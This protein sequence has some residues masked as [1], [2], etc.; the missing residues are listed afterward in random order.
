MHRSWG[1]GKITTVDTVFARFTID[2][3]DQGRPHDGSGLCRR[4]AQAH[5]QG[6]HSRPQSFR[7]RRPA[8]DG[9]TASSRSDQ[10]RSQSYGGKATVDQIQQVLVPDVIKDDWKKWWEAAKTRVEEGRPFPSAAQEDRADHLSGQGSLPAGPVA[11]RFPRGQ[12]SEGPHRCRH[13]KF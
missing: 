5:S 3:P 9:R 12:R 11:R 7:S 4:I 10:T 13:A 8:P 6:S 2:F 1:F